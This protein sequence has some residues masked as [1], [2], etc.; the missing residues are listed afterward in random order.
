M[1][2]RKIS[3]KMAETILISGL[4]AFIFF[5]IILFIGF[6]LKP[7]KDKLPNPT[8]VINVITI[9]NL[10]DVTV[11]TIEVNPTTTT[12]PIYSG[13]I[14]V[15]IFVKITGTNGLGLRMRTDPGIDHQVLFLGMDAE[16]F[17]VI[18]GPVVNNDYY[19][20]LLKSSYDDN[21]QGWAAANYL[22]IVRE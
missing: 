13:D 6:L 1:V 2:R 8:A 5:T 15:G 21:R 19:W 14:Q 18:D 9:P 17:E 20:W 3:A 10:N 4:V 22:E 7:G 12:G 16:I 11:E